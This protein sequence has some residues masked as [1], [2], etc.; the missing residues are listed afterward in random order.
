MK[1][2]SQGIVVSVG[3]L[4]QPKAQQRATIINQEFL[5]ER[6]MHLVCA[7]S[8]LIAG[9]PAQ[10]KDLSRWQAMFVIG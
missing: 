6:D 5:L 9:L 1:L 7:S 8:N 4:S 3:L 2:S 10:G